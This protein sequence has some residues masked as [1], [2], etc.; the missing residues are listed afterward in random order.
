M[1]EFSLINRYF[2][3]I[4]PPRNDVV[5]GIG[6]DAA[7][8]RIP[9][10][11]DLLVSTDTMVE[12]VHFLQGWDA[13]DIASKAVRVNVSDMAAMAATPCWMTLALTLPSV[14]D[15]WLQRF[16][17]GLAETIGQFNISLV[18][19]DTTRGPLTI[20]I[21]IHG[22]VPKGKAVRRCGANVGDVIVVTGELGA[23]ALAVKKLNS[24]SFDNTS[25]AVVMKQ[26]LHPMP[27]LDFCDF[28]REHA[29]AAIDISDGLTA[30]LN[31][32]LE[33]SSV[34]AC[35]DMAAI[36][37]HPLLQRHQ[38]DNALDLALSGGDDYELCFTVP[39]SALPAL[40]HLGLTYY[41]VGV[42]ESASGLRA[43]TPQGDIVPLAAKGYAHF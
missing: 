6:D 33:A 25:R 15:T 42:I 43:K 7:C 31:H 1:N 10:D 32:I 8:M 14:N 37:V 23:A 35:L 16:S 30:D 29:T 5:F 11:M 28:L 21:T 17:L 36:P 24:T 34:G 2:H 12:G 27:R 22:L 9:S 40:K 18:G 20:T 4:S 38:A 19:G 39:V 26:L 41:P 13:Y 3:S